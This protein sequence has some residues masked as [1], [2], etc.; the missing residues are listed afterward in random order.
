MKINFYGSSISSDTGIYLNAAIDRTYTIKLVQTSERNFDLDVWYINTAGKRVNLGPLH[1]IFLKIKVQLR[2][3]LRYRTLVSN[4]VENTVAKMT[5]VARAKLNEYLEIKRPISN[6]TSEKSVKE[7]LAFTAT[8]EEA[9]TL[10]T[11]HAKLL[12]IDSALD[13]RDSELF[14]QLVQGAK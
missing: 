5:D 3:F 6:K 9:E 4:K 11:E 14:Y 8:L 12:A 13:N 1:N 7:L 10:L 2:D